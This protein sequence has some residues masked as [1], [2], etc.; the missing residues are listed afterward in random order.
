MTYI[1]FIKYYVKKI[2]VME[3]EL[4]SIY[5]NSPRIHL[6]Q[7][8]KLYVNKCWNM[9]NNRLLT[10]H[11]HRT[12]KVATGPRISGFSEEAIRCFNRVNSDFSSVATLLSYNILAK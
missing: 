7:K 10:F 3:Y 5:L 8:K 6:I 2:V 9:P 1:T 12:Q 4:E 11:Y